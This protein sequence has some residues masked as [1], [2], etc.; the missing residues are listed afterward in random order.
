[1]TAIDA[2]HYLAVGDEGTY[3]HSGEYQ[4]DAQQIGA[5][6][7]HLK[8]KK[9]RELTLYFHGVG[10]PGADICVRKIP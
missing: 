5:I 2:L 8:A 6:I 3:S 1:M 4:S 9:I 7:G 10:S